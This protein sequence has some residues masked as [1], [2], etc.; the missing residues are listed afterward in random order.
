MQSFLAVAGVTLGGTS[1]MPGQGAYSLP[2]RLP[3]AL[4]D[5]DLYV[6]LVAIDPGTP[7]GVSFSNGVRMHVD[8]AT[9]R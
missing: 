4:A 5:E 2:V 8:V 6:Q 7:Q 3:V 1:G 9:S